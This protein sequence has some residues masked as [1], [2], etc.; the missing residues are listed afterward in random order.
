LLTAPADNHRQRNALNRTTNLAIIG[1]DYIFD[2]HACGLKRRRD[3]AHRS[4][5]QRFAARARDAG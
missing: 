3:P 5:F 4:F 2:T 1:H